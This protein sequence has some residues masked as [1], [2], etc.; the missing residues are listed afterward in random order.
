LAA[1][2]NNRGALY[3]RSDGKSVMEDEDTGEQLIWLEHC[4]GGYVTGELAD[5]I[6]VDTEE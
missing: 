3:E 4:E 6:N 2:Q 5:Q 1:W